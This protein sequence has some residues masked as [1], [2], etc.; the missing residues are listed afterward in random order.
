MKIVLIGAGS[1]IFGTRSVADIL[2][3]AELDGCELVLVDT[4]SQKLAAMHNLATKLKEHFGSH[5]TI[6]A[7]TERR[8]ALSGADYVMISV[9]QRR[10]E[11]WEQDF[12]V[13][14]AY[15]FAQAYAENG[16]PGALF[17]ALRNIHLIMAICAD[18]DQLC[19]RAMLFNYSNPETRVL[20]AILTLTRIN[21]VGLCH[22]QHDAL[23]AIARLLQRS[24]D[25]ID[26]LGGGIN[27]FFWLYT[28]TDR[29]TGHDLYPEL[30]QAAA[31]NNDPHFQLPKKLL[32]IYGLFTYPDNSHT[33]EFLACGAEYMGNKWLHGLESR[34]VT[35]PHRSQGD[36]L[37]PYLR[38]ERPIDGIAVRSREMA[39]PMILAHARDEAAR[40]ISSNVL[41]DQLWIPNLPPDGIVEVPA[42]VDARGFH[43]EA[44]PPLPDGIAALL[45]TQ[46]AIQ[47]LTV[48]A[49]RERSRK[50]L[51]QALLLEPMVNSITRAEAL[52]DDMLQLQSDYLPEFD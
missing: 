36:P 30:R 47:K 41:N 1:H 14:A 44:V 12:R 31:A 6:S 4:D 24:E 52:I 13:P 29:N 18:I 50:L 33:G 7:H 15:G 21:A 16:G 40:F 25:S 27:H 26:I 23:Q 39:V 5:S 46:M 17:H 22:G 2:G 19:P 28:I 35:V 37:G 8:A 43:P 45:R 32:D 42:T 48:S 49:Y 20:L 10:Y 34:K 11:L 51:L 3:S 9:T 38:G